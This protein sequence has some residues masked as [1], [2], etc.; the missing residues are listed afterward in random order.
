VHTLSGGTIRSVMARV[1]SATD[2]LFSLDA[3][4]PPRN[5]APVAAAAAAAAATAA[6][7]ASV[8]LLTEAP[9]AVTADPFEPG[10][11]YGAALAAPDVR[12]PSG[13]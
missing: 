8:R 3:G 1:S 13:Q 7:G 6:S 12:G 11:A 9:A 4:E 5:P 2:Q 10:V